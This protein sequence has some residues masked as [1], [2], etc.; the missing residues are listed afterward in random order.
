ME[1]IKKALDKAREERQKVVQT[2]MVPTTRK[3]ELSSKGN[4]PRVSIDSIPQQI[5]Y[6]QT[7]NIEISAEYLRERRVIAGMSPCPFIDAYKVLRTKVIQ[8]MRENKW[9]VLAVTSPGE[10][11]GKTLTSIN[12]AISL[13]LEVDQTVLLVDANLRNP[14]VHD[15]FGF[16]AQFGLSDYLVNDVPIEKILVH[17]KGIG[18]FVLLPGNKSLVDSSEMLSSPKMAMLVEELKSRYPSRLVIF[19]LPDLCTSDTLAFAPH[20]DAT[21]LIVEAGE[22]KKDDITRAFDLLKGTHPIGTVLNKAEQRPS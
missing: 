1:K 22:T 16:T 14:N 21:L 13:A 17:P 8:S 20:A 11:A 10:N 7:Q 3:V 9:N 5:Q 15:Y 2:T 18:R 4:L 6:A 19:D 12:L